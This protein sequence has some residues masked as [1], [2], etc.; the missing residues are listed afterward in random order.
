MK[1]HTHRAVKNLSR[2]YCF[3]GPVSDRE[4]RA[5]HGNICTVD[6]CKCGA[7]RRT[8]VNG[9]HIEKGQWTA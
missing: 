7:T 4:N 6:T 2:D 5:A 3:S 8:N 9:R 1:K